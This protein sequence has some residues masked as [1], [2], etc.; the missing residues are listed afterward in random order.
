MAELNTV[1]RTKIAQVAGVKSSSGS[2]NKSRTQ[3]I[4][5]AVAWTAANGDTFGTALVLPQGTRFHGSVRI[6]SAAGA[7]GSTVSL[8][9]RNAVN[10]TVIDAT[11]L[12]NGASIA[13]AQEQAVSTGTKLINGQFFTLPADC[14]IFGTFGGAAPQANQAIRIEVTFVSA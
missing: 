6:S 14:E 2:F 3:Y 13:T 12:V 7:A 10:G 1:T 5:T 4:D 9:L 8:G 11:A